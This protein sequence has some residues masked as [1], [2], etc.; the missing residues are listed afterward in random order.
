[1]PSEKDVKVIG[2]SGK[3]S[4]HKK[5]FDVR[6]WRY[7]ADYVREEWDRR[8]KSRAPRERHWK[9][10]D[11]QVAMSPSQQHKS[12]PDGRPD[13]SKNWM[14]DME[15]PLQAQALEVQV[16]DARR[17][18]F[19]EGQP[20]FEAHAQLTDK[21]LDKVDFQALVL[22]DE[23]EVPSQINQDNADK[24][25][26][27]YLYH[28][29][30]QND[31]FTRHDKINAEAIKY[32][33]GVGRL[34]MHKKSIFI[35]EAS[36]SVRRETQKIPVIVPV[37]IKN[38]YLDDSPGSMHSAT[39]LGPA[40]IAEDYTR[41][42]NLQLAANKGSNDPFKDDGGWMPENLKD[43]EADKDGYVTVLE[44]EGDLVVPRA[45]VSSLVIP[46]AIATVIVGTKGGTN[47]E[48]TGVIRFRF[49]KLP[50][51][52]YSLWPYHYEGT[53]DCYPTSPLEKGRPVQIMATD[54]LNRLLDS[55]ALKNAPP[56]SYDRMDTE[57]ALKGGPQVHPYAKWGTT[58][59]VTVHADVGG[60]P[61]AMAQALTL[62]LN[63]YG[64]LTG[65][66]PARLGAQT[67]SHTTAFAKGAELDRGAVRTV[68]Y[69][70]GSGHGP[71]T[72]ELYMLYDMGRAAI[73]PGEKVSFYIEA[74]GGW[75]EI[76]RDHLPEKSDFEWFGSGGPSEE[77][78]KAQ[79]KL[80]SLQ[81]AVQ[82]D[83]LRA[84]Q[85]LS[86]APSTVNFDAAIKQVLRQGGWTDIDA[87]T[88]MSE[89]AAPQPGAGTPNPGA[90]AVALQQL[91]LA[92][93]Q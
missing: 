75:V 18:M 40:H 68:D 39:E 50:Y 7:I 54:A 28:L 83:Q 84:Q 73:G 4:D 59:K 10:I 23:A 25:V 24:L 8:K 11:R 88:N 33:M 62:A 57:F 90:Q 15:L 6:D 55:A 13:V 44:Y 20:W 92:A 14:A 27:G 69:V 70:K 87:I 89:A 91:G 12:L 72:R 32:G 61:G 63:L 86:G 78:E 49:R 80:Q 79:R 36:G 85:V 19:A 58:E 46:G 71:L 67:V 81:L 66:L 56:V 77:Q 31:F 82:L 42:E 53:D 93:T 74:Y 51:S 60:D 52:S 16:A 41:L 26:E 21:Y 34:R 17:F 47:D 2:R 64:E 22:G 76:N 30:K 3:V 1:M 9:D 48:A 45:T 5:R 65:V 38:L 43:I 29:F 35:H 37:S